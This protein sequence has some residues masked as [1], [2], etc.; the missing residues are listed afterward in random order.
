MKKHVPEN[1]SLGLSFQPAHISNSI[2]KDARDHYPKN[3]DIEIT[4]KSGC[5]DSGL[6]FLQ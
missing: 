5:V 1:C 2:I 6:G 4:S 3:F